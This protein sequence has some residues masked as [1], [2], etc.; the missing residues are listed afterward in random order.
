MCVLSPRDKIAV[1]M[2]LQIEGIQLEEK[3]EWLKVTLPIRRNWILFGL[4]SLCLLVWLLMLSGIVAAVFREDFGFLLNA[5]LLIWSL[6]WLWF[7]RVL[8]RRWQFFAAARE[9]LFINDQQLIVRRPV[10]ILGP[11]DVYDMKHVSPFYFSDKHRCPAFDY[12]FQHV[13]FGQSLLPEEAS[14]LRDVLNDRHF[15]DHEDD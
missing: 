14:Q 15:P 7:G 5:M 3:P 12:G 8:W 9:V 11:T 4:F 6:I 2:T 1:D 10:S 13:Y